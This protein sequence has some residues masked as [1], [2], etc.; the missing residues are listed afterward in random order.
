M[1]EK[2]SNCIHCCRL[3]NQGLWWCE[4]QNDTNQ[5]DCN[6]YEKRPEGVITTN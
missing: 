5:T 6:D 1:N 2:C 4:L 3:V